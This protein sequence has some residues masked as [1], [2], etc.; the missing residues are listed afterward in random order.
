MYFAPPPKNF[1]KNVDGVLSK[2]WR[3]FWG[4]VKRIVGATNA[5]GRSSDKI[6]DD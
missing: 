6:N 3:M 4:R 2:L 1:G 5:V